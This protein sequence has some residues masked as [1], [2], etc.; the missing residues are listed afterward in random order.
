NN[1]GIYLAPNLPAATYRV[2][3]DATGFGTFVREP[4]EVRSRV[5]VKVDAV[6][7]P[8]TVNEAVSVS[9][10]APLLDTAAVNNSAS[11]KSTLIQELPMI[12]VGTKRDITSF[13][14]NLPGTTNTNTFVPSVN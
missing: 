9:A 14:N 7:Q 1:E 11:M 2:T 10:D 4:V 8:G 6:L 12:V 5:E 3:I 13:L